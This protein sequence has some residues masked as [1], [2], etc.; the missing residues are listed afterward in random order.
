MRCRYVDVIGMGTEAYEHSAGRLYIGHSD[1]NMSLG[2]LLLNPR[3]EFA[4]HNRP[5]EEQLTQISG[6]SLIK[7]LENDRSTSEVTLNEG[8]IIKIPANQ[9]HI[10]ANPFEIAS[11]TMWKFE[12][13]ITKV[14]EDIRKSMKPV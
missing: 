14:I 12:G 13:D 1:R 11:V 10:H 5:V 6:T 9:F 4:K 3:T 7:L 8:S 2:L